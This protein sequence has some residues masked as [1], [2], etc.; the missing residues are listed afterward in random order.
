[1]KPVLIYAGTT[2]GRELAQALQQANIP[3]ILS[4]AT[5]YGKEVALQNLSQEGVV[6]RQ[7]RRSLEEMKQWAK[8]PLTCIVDATHPFATQVSRQILESI[9]GQSLPFFRISRKKQDEE[10]EALI[11]WLQERQLYYLF[12]DFSSCVQELKKRKDTIFFTTGSKDLHQLKGEESFQKQCIL[13]VLPGKESIALCEAAGFE[14]KQIIAMQ[15]PFSKELNVALLQQYQCGALV[16]KESGLLGGYREKLQ[17]AKEL[18]IPCF[19]IKNPENNTAFTKQQVLEEIILL[20]SGKEPEQKTIQAEKSSCWKASESTYSKGQIN[21]IGVGVGSFGCITRDSWEQ[22][23]ES[24]LLVGTKR[25]LEPWKAQKEV[26]VSYRWEEMRQNVLAAYEK[27]KKVSILFSGDT[28]CYSGCTKLE[29]ALK[30]EQLEGVVRFP[31]ISSLSYMAMKMGYPWEQTK[32]CHFHGKEVKQWKQQLWST[33]WY[34]KDQ[35]ILTSGKHQVEEILLELKQMLPLE[36]EI[37]IGAQLSYP[38]EFFWKD[39]LK[40]I[41][42][43]LNQLSEK[44]LCTLW[45]HQEYPRQK[46]CVP[47]CKDSDFWRGNVPMT[48]EHVRHFILCQLGLQENEVFY[49]IGCGTGSIGIEAAT[50][51]PSCQIYG[52]DTNLEAIR[53]T[54]ENSRK[55]GVPWL[56]TICGAAPEVLWELPCYDVAF[57]GGTKGNLWDILTCLEKKNPKGRVVMS[58]ITIETIDQMHQIQRRFSLTNFQMVQLQVSYLEPLGNYHHWKMENTIT[59]CSFSFGGK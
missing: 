19:V 39:N 42:G 12:E 26:L 36:T 3:V 41:S 7:G 28:G 8:E 13:R 44:D 9:K 27:G 38:E 33:L 25:L 51:A 40:N 43:V 23:Q 45:I 50:V 15:G 34:E 31:G 22:I 10:T 18:Q 2:E 47:S 4:V 24:D 30:Q 57:I 37:G 35:C 11:Q 1:M 49:D 29:E 16:T 17:A 5:E 54:E 59:I 58:G 48:K 55:F 46:P 52:I 6:I 14:G 53:L 20:Y 21:L 32:L 56:T